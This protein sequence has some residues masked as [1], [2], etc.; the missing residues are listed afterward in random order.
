MTVESGETEE[1]WNE[2]DLNADEG[3]ITMPNI[4]VTVEGTSNGK[5]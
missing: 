1:N 4:D 3:I 5:E 2:M